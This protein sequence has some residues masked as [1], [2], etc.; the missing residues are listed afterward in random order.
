MA[1]QEVKVGGG[2]A[3]APL[4]VD[5][6]VLA[7][8]LADLDPSLRK[9]GRGTGAR[10]GRDR[11]TVS[12]LDQDRAAHLLD[13]GVRTVQ[14]LRQG[15]ARRDLIAPGRPRDRLV[16]GL[17]I[18]TAE[19]GNLAGG[20]DDRDIARRQS[21]D[22]PEGILDALQGE[23]DELA[24]VRVQRDLAQR[25]GAV[26]VRRLADHRRDPRIVRRDIDDVA[27]RP[28][29]SP[30]HDALRIDPVE[31]ARELHRR[32]VVLAMTGRV[33]EL[34][35]LAGRVAEAPVVEEQHVEPRRGEVLREREQGGIASAA[36]P[37]GHDDAWPPAVAGKG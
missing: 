13:P 34:A 7:R 11:V 14:V 18:R 22:A 3:F 17:G 4:E 30:E 21:T 23:L 8:V 32:P 27:A 36:D 16:P 2:G 24:P 26:Q 31:A 19:R 9:P 37:M 35:W 33:A 5:V 25:A 28:G 12:D 20:S 6:E 1:A 29:G 15:G 10:R